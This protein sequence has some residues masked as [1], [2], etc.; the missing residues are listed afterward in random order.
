MVHRR[1]R[2][3][4]FGLSLSFLSTS[5]NRAQRSPL[6]E[7]TLEATIEEAPP[8]A[9]SETVAKGVEA[10]EGPD[11][12]ALGRHVT[13]CLGPAGG[14]VRIGPLGAVVGTSDGLLTLEV[15]AAALTSPVTV[16]IAPTAAP[17]WTEG[18]ISHVYDFSPDVD[19]AIPARLTLGYRNADLPEGFLEAR[20]SLY[21]VENGTWKRARES[22]IDRR[23]HQV[24]APIDRLRT[25]GALAPMTSL[26][27]LSPGRTLTVGDS[28]VFKAV[29]V[30]EGRTVS[31]A[32]SPR[33]VAVID[34]RT[35]RLTA[36]AAGRARVVA[37]GAS[38]MR[39]AEVEVVLPAGPG[40][41]GNR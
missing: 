1:N 25:A 23:E 17:P 5:C 32:V 11:C 28:Q 27:I 36:L 34:S 37:S 8:A 18:F 6:R 21:T 22:A 35:G 7:P 14:S 15:P 16:R 10:A 38:L 41:H 12:S 30:P 20:L 33:T 39:A 40:D 13:H 29:T 31:W 2:W 24:S 26:A 9:A 3:L 19:F 4:L